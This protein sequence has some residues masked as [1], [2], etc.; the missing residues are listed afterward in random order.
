MSIV[1][2]YVCKMNVAHI[3]QI[4]VL[5]YMNKNMNGIEIWKYMIPSETC[6][7]L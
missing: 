1:K 6:T 4:A 5:K 3:N 7:F 2:Y